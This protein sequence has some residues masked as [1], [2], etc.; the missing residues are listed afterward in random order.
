MAH[1]A[2]TLTLTNEPSEARVRID[3]GYDHLGFTPDFYDVQ[4]SLDGAQTWEMLRFG[5]SVAIQNQITTIYD[6]EFLT[7]RET[8]Y[9]SRGYENGNPPTDWS[10]PVSTTLKLSHWWLKDPFNPVLYNMEV[11][12]FGDAFRMQRRESQARF[13]PFGRENTVVVSGILHG[14]YFPDLSISVLGQEENDRFQEMYAR[15]STLLLQSP[16]SR[17]WYI[18]FG[19]ELDENVINTTDEFIEYKIDAYQQD[20]P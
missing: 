18:R 3:I 10:D 4:H 19:D 12:L 8:Y 2:P 9:R 20:K 1:D 15:Q 6:Y 11:M 13:R 5:E 16:M 7:G 14:R 17:Q